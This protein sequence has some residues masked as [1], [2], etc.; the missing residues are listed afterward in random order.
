MASNMAAAPFDSY[1][2]LRGNIK[3]IDIYYSIVFLARYDL[4][5]IDSLFIVCVIC[6]RLMSEYVGV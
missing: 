3:L 6:F 1:R 2:V 4:L 5:L